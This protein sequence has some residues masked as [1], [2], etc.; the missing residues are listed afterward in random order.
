MH[1]TCPFKNPF[2]GGG[3]ALTEALLNYGAELLGRVS[4]RLAA[5]STMPQVPAPWL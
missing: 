3:V 4:N 1:V 5:A 2:G